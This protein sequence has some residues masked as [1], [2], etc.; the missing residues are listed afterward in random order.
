MKFKRI[1]NSEWL[2]TIVV[3]VVVVNCTKLSKEV[4]FTN[5]SNVLLVAEYTKLIKLSVFD[6]Y[7]RIF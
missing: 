2:L 6:R 7:W 5:Y 4:Y 1:L 3:V